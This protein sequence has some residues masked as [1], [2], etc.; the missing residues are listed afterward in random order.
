V[1]E[2]P[3]AERRAERDRE[4][5][6][7]YHKATSRFGIGGFATSQRVAAGSWAK[8]AVPDRNVSVAAARRVIM[9]YGLRKGGAQVQYRPGRR[10]RR[11]L[12]NLL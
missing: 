1:I 9:A 5:D 8:A 2:E 6:H 11:I 10:K 3:A 12:P 7:G 4:R